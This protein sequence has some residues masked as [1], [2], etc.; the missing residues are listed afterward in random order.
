MKAVGCKKSLPIGAADALIDFEA[1]KPEPTDRD[2]R[3]AVKAVSVNSADYNVRKRA[4]PLEARS[5]T[6]DIIM[7]S[8]VRCGCAN[9]SVTLHKL[10]I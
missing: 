8:S 10:A 1:P 5:R 6:A 9:R 2:I 3:V 7:T 4:E